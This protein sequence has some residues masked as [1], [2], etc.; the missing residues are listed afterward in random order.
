MK[1][2]CKILVQ[3]Q[4]SP[5]WIP[6]SQDICST[7]SLAWH[8]TSRSHGLRFLF[9]SLDATVDSVSCPHHRN[10]TEVETVATLC[11]ERGLFAG[12]FRSPVQW[13]WSGPAE[14]RL[15]LLSQKK[16]FLFLVSRRERSPGGNAAISPA[17]GPAQD[18]LWQQLDMS[19]T[20]ELL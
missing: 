2:S 17:T 20:Q 5:Q 6:C 9:S 15:T 16:I 3:M 10:M 18:A 8:A 1:I 7:T 13:G 4:K 11:S 14:W 12:A 19:A